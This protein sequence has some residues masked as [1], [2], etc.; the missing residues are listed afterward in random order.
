MVCVCVCVSEMGAIVVT[1]GLYN[2]I[3]PGFPFQS[4]K[5]APA[6]SNRMACKA[7]PLRASY[8]FNLHPLRD[9]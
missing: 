2:W 5:A 8:K 1:L 3:A 6:T 4:N 9:S 7:N